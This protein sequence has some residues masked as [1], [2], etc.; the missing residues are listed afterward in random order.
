MVK[1]TLK[2]HTSEAL[3][4]KSKNYFPGGVNSPVRAFKSVEGAPLFI[5]KGDGSIFGMKTIIN[6]LIFVVV[7]VL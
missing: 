5:K 7:G 4:E 6:L 3:F 2:R 1:H